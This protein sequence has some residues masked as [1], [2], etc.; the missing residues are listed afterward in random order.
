MPNLNLSKSGTALLTAIAM[1]ANTAV[2]LAILAPA[3]AQTEPTFSD[4]SSNYW[5]KDFISAL[6]ARDIIAGF[7]DGKFRPNAPVTRAQFATMVGKAF[8]TNS[9]REPINFVDV[10]SN[11]WAADAINE[12]YTTG[13]LSGYPGRVF[14]PNQRIPREQVL[15]SLASGLN[16]SGSLPPASVLEYYRDRRAIPNY[17]GEKIAAATEQGIVVNYPDVDRLKPNKIATR[18][19]VA[20]FIYQALV[21]SSQA[22]AI[23][24]PYIVARNNSSPPAVPKQPTLVG[25]VRIPSGTRLPVKYDAAERILV[26]PNE[27]AP[28]PL[29]VT[30]ARNVVSEGGVLLIPAGSQV[31]GELVTIEDQKSAQFV[32]K[33]L[34]LTNGQLVQIR[35]TSQI[36]SKIET[37][38]RRPAISGDRRFIVSSALGVA[39]AAAVAALTGGA[40]IGGILLGAGAGA[41]VN[42]SGLFRNR[43]RVELISIIPNTDLTLTLNADLVLSS[44]GK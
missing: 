23:V 27:P 31:I 38:A 24:S 15:V 28:V 11:Y 14:R 10:P 36:I 39:A 35:A 9:I 1:T 18:A 40:S 12:A 17:A 37:I 44:S 33:Q 32:A 2:T 19:E 30:I 13:F 6:A 41:G 8:N 43:D 42:L 16:Y 20:A 4:V 29:T 5:A 26:A 3:V 7:P 21:N 34:I 25:T 22:Q